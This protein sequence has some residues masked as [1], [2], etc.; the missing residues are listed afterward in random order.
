GHPLA[1]GKVRRLYDMLPFRKQGKVFGRHLETYLVV[2]IKTG[3]GK[4][5]FSHHK[6]K[7][8]FPFYAFVHTLEC[9][10]EFLHLFGRH[11][12]K[13]VKRGYY[14]ALPALLTNSP[15]QPPDTCI[16]IPSH[17]R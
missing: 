6:T 14:P 1:A 4:H 17:H 9:G 11:S 2:I 8:V 3:D 10:A 16:Y 12:T 5:L 7:M 13:I 15:Y